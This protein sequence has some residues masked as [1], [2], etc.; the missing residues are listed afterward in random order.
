[1]LLVSALIILLF[2]I[3]NLCPIEHIIGVPCPGC[4]MFTALY[5][6]FIKGDIATA[7]YYHPAVWAFLL[8]ILISFLLFLRYKEKMMNT[9]EFRICTF[10]FFAILIGVY[11]YR[12]IV[13]FP[14]YPMAINENALL[15][16]IIHLF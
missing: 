13:L 16:K 9:K 11:I 3:G 6:L 8:Y 5:W 1:M 2:F 14:Q 7:Q 4:N 15:I 12:M 10:I